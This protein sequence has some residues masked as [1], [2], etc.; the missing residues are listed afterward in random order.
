MSFTFSYNDTQYEMSASKESN[1]KTKSLS[2]P[3]DLEA[4]WKALYTSDW[5][6][7][8]NPYSESESL[9]LATPEANPITA[10][11]SSSAQNLQG[12]Y[13]ITTTFGPDEKLLDTTGFTMKL[14]Y[15]DLSSPRQL[16]ATFS[17]D[18]FEGIMRICPRGVPSA[19]IEEFEKACNLTPK[20]KPGSENPS[21][22]MRWRAK[23]G[24][25]RGDELV[26]HKN[27]ITSDFIFY[28]C[29]SPTRA[30]NPTL[31]IFIFFMTYNFKFFQFRATKIANLAEG[32]SADTPRS[33]EYKWKALYNPKWDETSDSD[34][35]SDLIRNKNAILL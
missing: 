18:K 9:P 10:S 17:F 23:D 7:D 35:E 16:Y 4:R 32:E 31:V 22:K 3:L 29:V 27:G 5:E 6:V 26:G 13:E 15:Y 19:T 2:S 24:G 25:M 14:L 20:S 34:S 1:L 8:K 30:G 33:L 12:V 28:S 21:W 11:A